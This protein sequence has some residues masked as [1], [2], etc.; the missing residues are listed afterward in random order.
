MYQSISNTRSRVAHLEGKLDSIVALMRTPGQQSS[1]T[2]PIRETSSLPVLNTPARAAVE[3]SSIYRTPG[4]FL[5]P[6]SFSAVFS[7][8]RG[9]F[10]FPHSASIS[11][12]DS[13][14][15]L[16]QQA[17]QAQ[18]LSSNSKSIIATTYE[19]EFSYDVVRLGMKVLSQI[20]SE[21][22]CRVLYS[23]HVNPNDGW[24]RLAGARLSA[25]IW[26]C[27]GRFLHGSD[28]RGLE[29]L[30]HLISRN[31]GTDIKDEGDT[32]EVSTSVEKLLFF[33]FLILNP[34]ICR[35]RSEC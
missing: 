31:T 3:P 1:V 17:P 34:R 11:N 10:E 32:G 33:F 14:V 5:G 13:P 23:R 29:A 15:E 12:R 21:E 8:N 22:A 6:T 4:S 35:P 25:S 26:P 28:S 24:V 20:P 9:N 19:E 2:G 18:S 16:P 7:E 30:S 27:F